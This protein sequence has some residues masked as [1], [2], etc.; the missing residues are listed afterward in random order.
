MIIQQIKFNRKILLSIFLVFCFIVLFQNVTYSND[1]KNIPIRKKR[2]FVIRSRLGFPGYPLAFSYSY[3]LSKNFSLEM[4]YIPYKKMSNVFFGVTFYTS[5]KNASPYL[6]IF[7]TYGNTVEDIDNYSYKQKLTTISVGV[8]RLVDS[9]F[10][11]EVG[12]AVMGGSVEDITYNYDPPYAIWHY[13]PDP[14]PW[15][16]IIINFSIGYAF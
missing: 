5:K 1:K 4:G 7:H 2:R 9:G 10:L 16:G 11:F 6:A 15:C 8:S 14:E 3:N 13:P 12:L